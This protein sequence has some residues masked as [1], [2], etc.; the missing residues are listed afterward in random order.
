MDDIPEDIFRSL[1]L[2][3]IWARLGVQDVRLRFRRS[4]LGVAWIFV[5]LTINILAI[6][7]IYGAL[8]KQEVHHFIPMLTIGL[9]IWSYLTSS[10]IDGGN[11]FVA[12]EGYIKQ[13]PL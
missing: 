1:S 11:A 7:L 5:T 9:V 12:S 8:F 3:R 4:S 6:G 13:I 2:W 10:I